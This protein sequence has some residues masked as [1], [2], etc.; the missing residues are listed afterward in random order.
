MIIPKNCIRYLSDFLIVN[1]PI[2]RKMIF[3]RELEE[4]FGNLPTRWNRS[5]IPFLQRTQPDGCIKKKTTLRPCKWSCAKVHARCPLDCFRFFLQK[6]TFRLS[7]E[8]SYNFHKSIQ[9]NYTILLR[10]I[11]DILKDHRDLK[12]LRQKPKRNYPLW[13]WD[14]ST[15]TVEMWRYTHRLG[16]FIPRILGSAGE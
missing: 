4:E 6:I 15:V 5:L 2:V 16:N 7:E 3:S 14:V 9:V 8:S 11:I 1:T 10:N 12:R 13:G